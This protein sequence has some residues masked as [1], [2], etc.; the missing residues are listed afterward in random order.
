MQKVTI[1]RKD[2]ITY[3]RKPKSQTK[4]T[5]CLCIRL[6]EETFNKLKQFNKPST[7]IKNI[8]NEYLER[9]NS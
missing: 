1:T 9:E 6:D 8:I 4:L 5:K 3:E 2:G 7:A